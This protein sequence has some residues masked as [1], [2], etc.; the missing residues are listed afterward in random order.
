MKNVVF[1]L[2]V[3]LSIQLNSL[4]QQHVNKEWRKESG[5]PLG[6]EWSQ[7]II[8]ENSEL[9]HVGNKN[10]GNE[11]ANVLLTKHNSNGDL[12]WNVEYNSNGSSNDY[13]ITLK[14]DNSGNVY[15]L[16]TSDNNTTD[17][18]DLVLLKVSAT[19]TLSWAT[20]YGS[21]FQKNDFGTALVVDPITNNIYVVGSSEGNSTGYDFLILAFDASGI[22]LWENRYDYNSLTE[23]PIGIEFDA[24]GNLFITG[25]SASALQSWDYTLVN[26]DMNGNYLNEVRHNANGL[27]FDEVTAYTKDNNGN[28]YITGKTA[29]NPSNIN[30]KTIKLNAQFEVQWLSIYDFDG[31]DDVA[32][33]ISV[34]PSGNILIAGYVTLANSETEALVLK[35]DIQGNEVW[36]HRQKGEV[37]Q[38]NAKA[39]AVKAGANGAVLLLGEEG[40][41]NNK[42]TTV[43]KLKPTGE[44][45]WQEKSKIGNSKPESINI[46]QD[47][48]VYVTSIEDET[49]TSDFK[50]TNTKYKT[51]ALNQNVVFDS[52]GKPK[53]KANELIVRFKRDAI[54]TEIIDQTTDRRIEFGNLSEF[55][56]PQA[57]E[58]F[59]R[60]I[61]NTCKECDVT[62]VKIFKQLKT[63][64]THTIN[65]LGESIKIPDFWTSLLLVFPEN[66]SLEDLY[67]DL[68]QANDIIAYTEP[69]FIAAVAN[70]PNDPLF[71]NQISLSPIYNTSGSENDINMLEA[72]E[73][74]PEA[75]K[76]FVK[77]GVM[78]EGIDF[79]HE[80]F[81]YDGVS[82]NSTKVA[83]GWSFQN[84]APLFSLANP[85][86]VHGTP[87]AG[88]IGALRNNNL[89]IT[90]IAGGDVDSDASQTGCSLY[91]MR[92]LNGD[93]SNSFFSNSLNYI[94]DAVVMSAID[95]DTLDYAYGLHISSNSWGLDESA[96][97]GWEP[98]NVR[99]LSEAY[100]FANRANVI[101]VAARGNY[102]NTNYFYPATF[103]DNW[104]LSIGGTGYYGEYKNGAEFSN[105][106]NFYPSY[107][108]NVDIGAPSE[109]YIIR[110][111]RK[112]NLYGDFGRTS[113]ATPHVSGVV[114]LLTG[115]L[116]DSIPSYNNLAPEDCERLIELSATDV[117][118]VGYDNLSGWGR[119]NAGKAL[120][121]VE[122]PWNTVHHFGTNVLSSHSKISNLTSP[123]QVITLT[124]HYQNK[125]GQW[126]NPGQYRVDQYEITTNVSHTLNINDSIVAAWSRP[127]SSSVLQ[128]INNDSITPH[129]AVEI[130]NLTD[131]EAIL[132]GYIYKVYNLN[133]DSLGWWP[134]DTLLNN[135]HFEYT[136]LARDRF[137]PNVSVQD[138]S[139]RNL[140]ITLFP[141]PSSNN[142]K[143]VIKS[144]NTETAIIDMFDLQGRI[145][146]HI[147]H[148][149]IDSELVLEVDISKLSKGMYMYRILVGDRSNS[150]RFIK[151]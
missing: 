49:N 59:K 75:G 31:K 15:V 36:T 81:G 24:N 84:N 77:C 32:T 47:L 55:L 40:N 30:I 114:A 46:A 29:T 10:A 44:V 70:E 26:Y 11:G 63:T 7:S 137:A 106:D 96:I 102:G 111:L 136:I 8:N 119:L 105:G 12:I 76:P 51:F 112:D 126:F 64:H 52:L 54:N 62:A 146:Q 4:A 72:W 14:E 83:G 142:Q 103:N 9:I 99:L 107:G 122:K 86:D 130:I 115:Y 21:P 98:A 5:N 41:Q 108:K 33:S 61:D 18:Y 139:N 19:G 65:R 78:D 42:K 94:Y 138:I 79:R 144:V 149:T 71:V 73:I 120:R 23:I 148:G 68:S 2:I 118:D 39:R 34:D 141:N 57:F 1:K 82:L 88:I 116:N 43:T 100:H 143:L 27:G 127:S 87:C 134:F 25:T 93:A 28:V 48:A 85:D 60:A 56:T 74:F 117:N 16:G 3:L 20:T 22:L 109:K 132:K 124:E 92:I 90:G 37:A 69:N 66:T 97:F 89:G 135:S 101:N 121:L 125:D 45:E 151:D 95:N 58:S 145:I 91:G 113:A 147:Y 6:L 38:Q 133:G 13:G 128:M 150:V 131:T 104:I 110:S 129:E 53:Y 80:D 123:N 67:S 140:G 17:N 50:Y 35:Y